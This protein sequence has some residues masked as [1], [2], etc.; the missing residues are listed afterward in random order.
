M[1][2]GAIISKLFSGGVVDIVEKVGNIA[3]KFIQTKEE[4]DAFS[5]EMTKVQAD[6]NQKANELAASIDEAYLKDTQD[7]RLAY[8]K[9][10]ES[11]NSS[12]LA[13]NIM[14]V[15][16]LGVTVG[17]FGL[18]VYMLK[19]EV[20]KANEAIMYTMLGSLGTAW[21]TMVG[22]Y[23]GSSQGSKTNGEALRKMIDNKK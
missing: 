22:F 1:P 21:I 13:K 17:F 18:L 14:P 8:S 23:F 2:V 6:I 16:T 4:K 10:Q 19:Y 11:E 7:A 9:I 5:L 3:D 20:P 12:W 15:L